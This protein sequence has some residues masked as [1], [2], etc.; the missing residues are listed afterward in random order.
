M[1]YIPLAGRILFSLV[2]IMFG[3]GHFTDAQM[4]VDSGMVPSFLPGKL[5]IV[6]LTGVVLVAGGLSVLVGYKA[7][8]GALALG[9]LMLGTTFLTWAPQLADGGQ[10]EMAMF[11]KD[12]ALAGGAFLLFH[13]GAGPMSLD[14]RAAG[15][16]A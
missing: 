14:A 15:S 4:M 3:F 12:M 9:L 10:V 2:F 1:Q 5:M 13:F 6:Y 16:N 11:M 7:K 8:L